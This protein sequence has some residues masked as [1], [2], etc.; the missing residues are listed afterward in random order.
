MSKKQYFIIFI[1]STLLT[2]AMIGAMWLYYQQDKSFFGLIDLEKRKENNY[3]I[4]PNKNF[5]VKG[6]ELIEFKKNTDKVTKLQSSY[7]SV[8]AKYDDVVAKYNELL[9]KS[10][11]SGQKIDSISSQLTTLAKKG[12]IL[13]DSLQLLET[14][15]ASLKENYKIAQE[16]ITTMQSKLNGESDS[17]NM[18][19]YEDFAKI[20]NNSSPADVAKILE[21][22]DAKKSAYIL[23]LMSKKK[24]GKV[25]ESLSSEYAA[26]V[27]LE[28]GKLR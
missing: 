22:L 13:K 4:D 19:K 28:S 27:L 16:K 20:Y 2:V 12:H 25:I 11:K 26:K 21:N 23:K 24:A 3:N 5:V 18:A 17:L 7:E 15:I 9:T 10:V 1:I 8:K 14:Q 6:D